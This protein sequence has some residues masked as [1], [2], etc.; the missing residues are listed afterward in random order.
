MIHLFNGDILN[1]HKPYDCFQAY[2]VYYVLNHR[3]EI[4]KLKITKVFQLAPIRLVCSGDAYSSK[5]LC[6]LWK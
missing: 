6:F 5:L 4:N 3:G 1:H 2:F